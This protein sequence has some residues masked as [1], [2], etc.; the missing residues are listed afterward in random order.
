MQ[1]F[2]ATISFI[3]YYALRSTFSVY[4][5]SQIDSVNNLD[6][7]STVIVSHIVTQKH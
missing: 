3:R 2:S 1:F 5:T 7:D 6:G 4:D